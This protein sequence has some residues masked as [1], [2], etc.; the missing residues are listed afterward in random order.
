MDSQKT[1][2]VMAILL[3]I[4]GFLA[5]LIYGIL[6]GVYDGYL[7]ENLDSFIMGVLI[8]LSGITTTFVTFLF[9]KKSDKHIDE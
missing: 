7:L 3:F 9:K 4:G 2:R 8:S 5:M 6:A 1:I